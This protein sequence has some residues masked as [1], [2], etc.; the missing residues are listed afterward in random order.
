MENLTVA[1][2]IEKLKAFDPDL[3]VQFDASDVTLGDLNMANGR[4]DVK[5]AKTGPAFGF[6]L[7]ALLS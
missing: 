4:F 5:D 7:V 1:E 6:G 2:L 3:I